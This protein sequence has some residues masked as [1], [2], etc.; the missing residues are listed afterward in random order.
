[1]LDGMLFRAGIIY[2]QNLQST[3]LFLSICKYLC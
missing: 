3:G 2:T 1:M